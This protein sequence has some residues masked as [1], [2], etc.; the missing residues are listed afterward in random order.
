M[1]AFSPKNQPFQ[2]IV[3]RFNLMDDLYRVLDRGVDY[4]C[5]DGKTIN[6]DEVQEMCEELFAYLLDYHFDDLKNIENIMSQGLADYWE[7]QM[8]IKYCPAAERRFP[9]TE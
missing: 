3:D 2:T 1:P 9:E 5:V 6:Q 4:V 7:G 8:E